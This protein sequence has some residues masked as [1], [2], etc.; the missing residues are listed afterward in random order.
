MSS[1]HFV[2]EDQEPA[3][4]IIDA[5]DHR[6]IEPLLEWAPLIIVYDKVLE[7]L[8]SRGIRIDV[9][10]TRS[11]QVDAMKQS[12]TEYFPVEILPY[13]T[14][15][16]QIHTAF[17]FLIRRKQKDVTIVAHET[18]EVFELLRNF[19]DKMNITWVT[20]KIKWSS[21]QGGTY[22]KWLPGDSELF[23]HASDTVYLSDKVEISGNVLRT[24]G[25]SIIRLR[26]AAVFWVGEHL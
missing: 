19:T 5:L 15:E 21:V 4:L 20:D 18:P 25:D 26:S 2:K 13:Q 14:R 3:L 23:I 9:V 6:T 17:H 10:I 8:L 24:A 12:I 22:A 16:N 7:E 1:H 11:D